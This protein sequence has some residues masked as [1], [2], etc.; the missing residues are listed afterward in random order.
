MADAAVF[1]SAGR[2]YGEEESGNIVVARSRQVSGARSRCPPPIGVG[3]AEGTGAGR[4]QATGEE[5]DNVDRFKP[6]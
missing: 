2:N 6:H 3:V 1:A 5:V 4:G